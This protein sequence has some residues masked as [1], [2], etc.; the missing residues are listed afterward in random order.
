MMRLR[1]RAWLCFVAA[2]T[3]AFNISISA[4]E[5][6]I[7]QPIQT[8][9]SVA[10]PQFRRSIN[11]L[12]GPSMVDGNKITTLINGDQIFPAMLDAIRHAEKSITFE[13]YIW[14]DGKLSEEFAHAISE[15]AKAGVKCH[16]IV[17]TIA[18]HRLPRKLINEMTASGVRFVKYGHPNWWNILFF[19]NHRDHRKILVVDGKIGFAGGV[20]IHD[21]WLGNAEAPPLWRDTH[22][23][24][25]GP[26]VAQLQGVFVDNWVRERNRVLQGDAYFP[27]LNAVGMSTVQCFK[28]GPRDGAENARLNYL[29]AIAAARKNIRF[30]HAYFVPDKLTTKALIDAR[31][32]GVQIEVII[33]GPTDAQ[34]TKVASHSRWKQLLRAG[35]KFYEYQQAQYHCK[36]MIVDDVWTTAG[37]VNVDHRSFRIN[38]ENNFNVLDR[39][40]AAEQIRMFEVDKSKSR[41]LTEKDLRWGPLGKLYE[42][43][44]TM[45]RSQL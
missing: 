18:S 29:M 11:H 17:D 8:D 37:S 15:R 16:V 32:R 40:F 31:K 36:Q 39:T 10:D 45:F 26:A 1:N 38:A 23:R 6:E 41:L 3:L 5:K 12:L 43:F 44:A 13:T 21:S 34:I 33:P 2:S 9:Y 19:L 28:S 25:E 42:C 20:G 27:Q 22:Y 7:L 4:V 30:A 24:I 14:S 35:V